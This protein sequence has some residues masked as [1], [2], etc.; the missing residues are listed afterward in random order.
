MPQ[1]NQGLNAFTSQQVG[2]KLNRHTYITTGWG[3][4]FRSLTV[5]ETWSREDAKLP[6]NIFAVPPAL[7]PNLGTVGQFYHSGIHQQ[8]RKHKEPECLEGS[9][10]DTPDTLMYINSL[11][12][13]FCG[14]HPRNGQLASRLFQPLTSWNKGN[15]FFI[16]MFSILYFKDRGSEC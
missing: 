7:S 12:R 4:V 13:N 11:S 9:K 15:G 8:S 1:L 2:E 5:Q 3:G 10:P 16:Q 6:F 14:P